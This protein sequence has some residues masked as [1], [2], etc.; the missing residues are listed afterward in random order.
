VQQQ[1][2]TAIKNKNIYKPA[3]FECIPAGLYITLSSSMIPCLGEKLPRCK[4]HK[5][6]A[7]EQPYGC[8]ARFYNLANFYT[9]PQMGDFSFKH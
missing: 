5:N 3:G 2:A 8:E 9:T 1:I 7:P 4:A 6:L